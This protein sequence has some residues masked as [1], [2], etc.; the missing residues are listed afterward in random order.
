MLLGPNQSC[1]GA[2]KGHASLPW[3]VTPLPPRRGSA[4]NHTRVRTYCTN[5]HLCQSFGT[6]THCPWADTP[7]PPRRGSARSTRTACG[8]S[9]R[10]TAAPAASCPTGSAG[11]GGPSGA[12]PQKLAERQT[13]T[14]RAC[15]LRFLLLKEAAAMIMTVRTISFAVRNE[16]IY[17]KVMLPFCSLTSPVDP[18]ASISP[19]LASSCPSSRTALT[20]AASFHGRKVKRTIHPGL[21]VC[22]ARRGPPR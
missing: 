9:P 20:S 14:P 19:S 21:F 17:G 15:L 8:I 18:C 13:A 5:T 16:R 1:A 11:G 3:V 4:T 6:F 2:D 12:V 7:S 10:R 22:I